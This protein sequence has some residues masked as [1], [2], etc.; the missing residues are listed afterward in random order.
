M[1]P[2]ISAATKASFPRKK[3][4][5]ECSNFSDTHLQRNPNLDSKPSSKKSPSDPDYEDQ[6]SSDSSLKPYDPLTNYLSPRPK[7][8]RYNPNRRREIFLYPKN[9]IREL[10][11]GDEGKRNL[12][13]DSQKSLV[14]DESSI[15]SSQ[16]SVVQVVN[17][18]IEQS[19]GDHCN[20]GDDYEE[21]EIIEQFEEERVWSLKGVF[22][23]LLVMA[24]LVLSTL[25]ISSV[26]SPTPTSSVEVIWG[27]RDGHHEI[28]NNLF[29]IFSTK[30]LE[31]V[32]DQRKA[33]QTG[34]V[35]VK[36]VVE[37]DMGLLDNNDELETIWEV[38]DQL[39]VP[40]IGQNADVRDDDEFEASEG[41]EGCAAQSQGREQAE[42]SD[43]FADHQMAIYSP[44]VLEDE[45]CI[46]LNIEGERV[47]IKDETSSV[48]GIT[49]E[50]TRE[51]D[52]DNI[53]RNEVDEIVTLG[54]IYNEDEEPDTT[55]PKAN[56]TGVITIEEVKIESIPIPVIWVSLF[57]AFVASLG[58]GYR[59]RKVRNSVLGEKV[60]P[61]QYVER[62]KIEK[63]KPFT[64]P[65]SLAHSSVGA[66]RELSYSHVPVVELIGENSSNCSSFRRS[67]KKS[68]MVE[69]EESNSCSVSFEKG[70]LSYGSFTAEKKIVK[71]EKKEGKDGEEKMVITNPVRRSS[72]LHSRAVMSP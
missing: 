34:S 3:I 36:M 64:S 71:K 10:K 40:G 44:T 55:S 11:H 56:S 45:K 60:S 17:D 33:N 52:E 19:E 29:G 26:K 59:S 30:I 16:Q 25:Y 4:L 28:Q 58:F 51:R 15:S 47:E 18:Y 68:K 39:Q 8:L 66:R 49:K 31:G 23:F 63:D 14:E 22:K 62:E 32:Q 20:D 41:V 6:N 27:F 38:Y 24:A 9:Q 21:E 65:P 46:D 57:L 72:R 50:G 61:G 43:S 42:K 1:S 7:F 53:S 37:D 48:E 13:F 67:G 5:T 69:T 2:T 35:D 12:S 70:S 54:S